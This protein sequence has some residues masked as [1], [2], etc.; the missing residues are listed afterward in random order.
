MSFGDGSTEFHTRDIEHLL[1]CLYAKDKIINNQEAKINELHDK[2]N[3]NAEK[4]LKEVLT[5]CMNYNNL[6]AEQ[7]LNYIRRE[8][9]GYYKKLCGAEEKV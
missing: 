9:V 5:D 2:I 4:K 1:K 7:R 3:F 8:Y 6:S